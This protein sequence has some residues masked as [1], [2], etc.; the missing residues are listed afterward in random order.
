VTLQ[1]IAVRNIADLDQ[2]FATAA[3]DGAQG[4]LVFTH[5]FA[6][7]NRGRI[8]DLAA[9]QRLP[10]A[11][12]GSANHGLQPHFWNSSPASRTRACAISAHPSTPTAR[13]IQSSAK[14]NV[15]PA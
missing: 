11:R 15:P 10:M 13:F 9:R 12:L 14:W 4:M 1:P 6:V 5:G 2:A 3:R 7:L 8:M